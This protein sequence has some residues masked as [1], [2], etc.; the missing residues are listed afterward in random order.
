MKIREAIKQAKKYL[1]TDPE[2]AAFIIRDYQEVKDAD[3]FRLA[4]DLGCGRYNTHKNDVIGLFEY[5]EQYLDKQG[6]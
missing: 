2:L 4:Y 3:L 6:L 5:L 1:D